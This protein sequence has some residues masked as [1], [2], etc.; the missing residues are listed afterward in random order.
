MTTRTTA[1]AAATI[2]LI[3]CSV[4]LTGEAIWM[5]LPSSDTKCVSEEIQNNVVVLGD[6]VVISDDRSHSPTISVK[7][8]SPYGN[9]LHHRENETNGQFAFTTQE[10]GTYQACFSVD[11]DER[12][13]SSVSVSLDWKI[14]IAAQ[15]WDSVARKEKIEVSARRTLFLIII[16]MQISPTFY[17]HII[18]HTHKRMLRSCQ[19]MVDVKIELSTVLKFFSTL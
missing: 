2:L 6:Y 17:A 8:T 11:G 15:D 12:E 9:N 16:Q 14:G 18:L 3:V 1:T 4:V 13:G 7:I 10:S 19:P 5:N